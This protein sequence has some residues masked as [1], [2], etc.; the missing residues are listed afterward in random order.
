MTKREQSGLIL[1]ATARIIQRDGRWYVPSQKTPTKSYVV[2]LEKGTCTC[3]DHADWSHKCKHVFAAEI[4]ARRDHRNPEF[5]ETN[6]YRDGDEVDLTA[7]KKTYKQNW[8]AY[9]LAQTT[10]KDR[11][12]VLLHDLCKPLVNPP[13]PVGRPRMPLSDALFALVFKTYAATSLRRFMP[14]FEAAKAKGYVRGSIHF[15]AIARYMNW[16]PMTKALLDLIERSSLPLRAVETDFAVD[17]TGFSTSRFVRWFDEKYG[18][19]KSGHDWV[20]V[21]LMAGVKTH[22]VTAVEI[23]HRNANDAPLFGPL[24]ALTAKNF[25]V[26]EVSADKA[27]SSLKNLEQTLAV[28]AEPYIPFKDNATTFRGGVWAKM[29]LYYQLRREEFLEHYHKRSNAE[30]VFAMIKAKFRDHVRSRSNTA[31]RNEALAKILC[32]NICVVIQS[33]CELGIEPVFWPTEGQAADPTSTL[34]RHHYIE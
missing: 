15:N 29:L 30:S 17:S 21:H 16:P 6:P 32:H 9:N 7:R 4:V 5:T 3:P 2:N 18:V 19:E 11:F 20:K 14:D 26:K 34:A 31:M 1:A 24:L 23:R 22:V 8:T 13:H 33:Q 28:G 10:E 25:R 12:Q 27:Y